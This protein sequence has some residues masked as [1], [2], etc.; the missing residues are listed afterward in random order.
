MRNFDAMPSTPTQEV[1]P[2][3]SQPTEVCSAC[4]PRGMPPLSVPWKSLA[5]PSQ[6]WCLTRGDPAEP[7]SPCLRIRP[8]PSCDVAVFSLDSLVGNPHLGDVRSSKG[9]YFPHPA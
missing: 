8:Q 2:R 3:Q 1:S 5:I 9:R 6:H 7:Q 4:S